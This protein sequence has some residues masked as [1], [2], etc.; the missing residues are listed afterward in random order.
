MQKPHVYIKMSRFLHFAQFPRFLDIIYDKRLRCNNTS[1]LRQKQRVI[2]A[3]Q[4]IVLV[5]R[6]RIFFS[7][8]SQRL[9]T[10]YPRKLTSMQ[11]TR[12]KQASKPHSASAPRVRQRNEP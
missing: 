6:A 7:S 10:A 3:R 1:T 8:H 12:V 11:Q 4:I 9:A 5:N 2:Y